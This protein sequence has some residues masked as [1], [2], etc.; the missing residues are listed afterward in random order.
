MHGAEVP[1]LGLRETDYVTVTGFTQIFLFK[2]YCQEPN[3]SVVDVLA[4]GNIPI[5]FDRFQCH[6]I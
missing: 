1:L 6:Y 5:I 2:V 4:D 3:V